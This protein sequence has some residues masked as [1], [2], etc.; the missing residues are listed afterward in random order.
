MKSGNSSEQCRDSDSPTGSIPDSN[1][2]RSCAKQQQRQMIQKEQTNLTVEWNIV[3]VSCTSK[4]VKRKSVSKEAWN[5]SSRLQVQHKSV[6]AIFKSEPE[7]EHDDQ[8]VAFQVQ[9]QQCCY[10]VSCNC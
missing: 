2:E 4:S 6:K 7:D 1:G 9:S 5:E 3:N 8:Q 10:S